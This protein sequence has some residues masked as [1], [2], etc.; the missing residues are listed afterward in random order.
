MQVASA[1]STIANNIGIV[2]ERANQNGNS[3]DAEE[4]YD[5]D[6]AKQINAIHVIQ[7]VRSNS[8]AFFCA[9]C[10]YYNDGGQLRALRRPCP[11][12]VASERKHLHKLLLHGQV[13]KQGTKLGCGRD[14]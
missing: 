10:G 4:M 2:N 12:F 14:E 5:W 11:S 8:E 9:K 7:S 1:S 6:F 13:P 3:C